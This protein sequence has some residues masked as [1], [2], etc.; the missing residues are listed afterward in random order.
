M[1]DNQMSDIQATVGLQV[2][3]DQI[4]DELISIYRNKD[5]LFILIRK[6]VGISDP[7]IFYRL[8][9]LLTAWNPMVAAHKDG[10]LLR[11]WR[12]LFE[13]MANGNELVATQAINALEP[14]LR[15]PVSRKKSSSGRKNFK[16]NEKK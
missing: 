1:T 9:G 7:E 10:L 11:L 14:L 8:K 12:K 2:T 13:A 15:P 4:L 3:D 6:Y 16:K 5:A